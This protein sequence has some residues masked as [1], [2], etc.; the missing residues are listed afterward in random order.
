VAKKLKKLSRSK[1]AAVAPKKYDITAREVVEDIISDSEICDPE[2]SEFEGCCGASILHGF[3]IDRDFDIANEVYSHYRTLVEDYTDYGI[4][5]IP[6]MSKTI[7]KPTAALIKELAQ[8]E[9]TI[10]TDN[11]AQVAILDVN[12][13]SIAVKRLKAEGFKAGVKW[14]NPSTESTLQLFT[15]VPA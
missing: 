1:K 12:R 6:T 5:E 8:K 13:Q 11:R 15:R 14:V 9:F 2:L 3:P 7:E 4:D 10:D